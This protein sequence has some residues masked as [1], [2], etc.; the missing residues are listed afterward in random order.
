MQNENCTIKTQFDKGWINGGISSINS[1]SLIALATHS[2]WWINGLEKY[3]LDVLRL[4]FHIIIKVKLKVHS[5]KQQLKKN[6]LSYWQSVAD[7]SKEIIT[8]MK[9]SQKPQWQLEQTI[10]NMIHI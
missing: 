3:I 8:I 2:N 7:S 1:W 10:K 5:V 9:Y 6:I 4:T